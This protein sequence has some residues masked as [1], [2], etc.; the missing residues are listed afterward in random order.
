MYEWSK[1]KKQNSN[2]K[3]QLTKKKDA[4]NLTNLFH[5]QAYKYIINHNLN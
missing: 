2:L 1:E 4:S 3:I 5:F